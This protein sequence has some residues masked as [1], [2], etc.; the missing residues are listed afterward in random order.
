MV[1]TIEV[2]N[3]TVKKALIDQVQYLIVLVDTSYNVLIGRL[4]LNA[5]GAII[6]TSHL[7]MKFPSSNDRQGQPEDDLTMLHIQS[8]DVDQ[9]F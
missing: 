1:I 9:T 3:F 8:Q 7:V 5:L 6:S 2:A 4:V